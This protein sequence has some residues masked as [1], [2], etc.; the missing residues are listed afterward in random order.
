MTFSITARIDACGFSSY[1]QGVLDHGDGWSPGPSDAS[2]STQ[3]ALLV[4][5]E[6][7]RQQMVVIRA[8][9]AQRPSPFGSEHEAKVA[10]LRASG[11]LNADQELFLRLCGTEEVDRQAMMA[12][13]LGP[14]YGGI[15][16]PSRRM[17]VRERRI[18]GFAQ[19]LLR[20]AREDQVRQSQERRRNLR[21]RVGRRRY[22]RNRAHRRPARRRASRAHSKGGGDP[23]EPPSALSGH[24]REEA[25]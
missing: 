24:D 4:V 22:H 16:V 18:Q 7:A 10:E 21:R 5:L 23:P 25:A 13:A 17:L 1:L 14:L 9:R 2:E 6:R 11:Y 20:S 15:E 19:A 12:R 8:G 3:R